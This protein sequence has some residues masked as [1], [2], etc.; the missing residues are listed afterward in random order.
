M[1]GLERENLALVH[2]LSQER[3]HGR[4]VE[5]EWARR[6]DTAR[7]QHK[8]NLASLAALVAAQNKVTGWIPSLYYISILPWQ[9]GRE[10]RSEMSSLTTKYNTKLR[11]AQQRNKELRAEL[12]KLQVRPNELSPSYHT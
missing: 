5:A 11:A 6:L 3:Q 2:Q 1:A 4:E 12:A 8:D 10:W 9:V 7:Q